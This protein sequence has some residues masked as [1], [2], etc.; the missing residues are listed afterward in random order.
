[1]LNC[2]DVDRKTIK[3]YFPFFNRF[4]LF[5]HLLLLCISLYIFLPFR[6]SKYGTGLQRVGYL[7]SVVAASGPSIQHTSPFTVNTPN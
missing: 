2:L 5:S 1:M 3:F 4:P 6:L 7:H